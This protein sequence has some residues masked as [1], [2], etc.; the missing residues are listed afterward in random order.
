MMVLAIRPDSWNFPLLLHVASAMVLVGAAV[1][2]AVALTQALRTSEPRGAA[3]LQRFG[4]RTLLWVAVP[5]SVL[6]N[7]DAEWIKSKEFPSGASDPAWIGWGYTTA[8]SSLI[9]LVIATILASLAVRRSR[10]G[11]GIGKLSRAATGLSLL[12]IAI[13]LIAIWAMTTKPS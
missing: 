4:A 2:A 1:V 8:T 10:A 6:L 5:M 7:V 9:F 12:S 13:L 3:A 11:S